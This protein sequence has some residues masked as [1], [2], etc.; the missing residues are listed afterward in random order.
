MNTSILLLFF[1]SFQEAPAE[2]VMKG[3]VALLSIVTSLPEAKI[4]ELKAL[5]GHWLDTQLAEEAKR[6]A[7]KVMGPI[8][9]RRPEGL[10]RP[11]RE[12]EYEKKQFA[13]SAEKHSLPICT[14]SAR[15]HHHHCALLV[16][17]NP[18]SF[19]CGILDF[20]FV[21]YNCTCTLVHLFHC[22]IV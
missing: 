11:H 1:L 22:T 17:A 20:A 15:R 14:F 16:V 4:K 18:T 19:L 9:H 3:S 21:R 8:G 6:L 5:D 13:V 12:V 2:A 10:F 7:P